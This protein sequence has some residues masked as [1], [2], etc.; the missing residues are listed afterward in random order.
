MVQQL[1]PLLVGT[2]VSSLLLS[3]FI[4]DS[5]SVEYEMPEPCKPNVERVPCLPKLIVAPGPPIEVDIPDLL[6]FSLNPGNN[7]TEFRNRQPISA[8]KLDPAI[9]HN[10]DYDN[11]ALNYPPSN[12]AYV[13]TS[14]KITIYLS[15]YLPRTI[16]KRGS[17]AASPISR[18]GLGKLFAGS[19]AVIGDDVHCCAA[20]R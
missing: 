8:P 15:Q 13:N 6:K 12:Y 7:L 2:L 20:A 1:Q 3:T 10:H 18:F 19:A 14:N 4:E 9:S 11:S 5:W 17:I 16:R